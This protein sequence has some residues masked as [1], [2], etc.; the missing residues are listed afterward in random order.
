M[1]EAYRPIPAEEVI[2]RLPAEVR[3]R[4]G[5]R[6]T[7]LIAAEIGRQSLAVASHDTG[8]NKIMEPLEGARD[9]SD[10]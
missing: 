3:A 6:A 8:D 1:T 10:I 4:I 9:R 5:S 7:E 2:A